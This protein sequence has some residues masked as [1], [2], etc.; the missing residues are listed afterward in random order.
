MMKIGL[1]D[2]DVDGVDAVSKNQRSLR[3]KM[4]DDFH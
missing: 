3:L 2:V 4:D 1:Q